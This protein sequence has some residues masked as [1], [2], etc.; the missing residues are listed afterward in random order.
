MSLFDSAQSDNSNKSVSESPIDILTIQKKPR[1]RRDF[2]KQ[3][4]VSSVWK[5]AVGR[6]PLK[7]ILKLGI[8]H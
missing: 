8:N 7:T 3:I 4:N 1:Q 2:P 5:M 6:I